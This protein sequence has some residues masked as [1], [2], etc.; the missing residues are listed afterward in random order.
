MDLISLLR[1]MGKWWLVV[2][3]IGILTVISAVLVNRAV[4]PIYEA[5]GAVVVT[6]PTFTA[7]A[8]TFD[9]LDLG[10]LAAA[11][12]QDEA[13][14]ALREADELAD[15]TIVD[16]ADGLVQVISTGTTEAAASSTAD[17]VA[18]LLI[19]ELDAVQED[20]DIE[21]A[22]RVRPRR[23]NEQA[24]VQEDAGVDGTQQF[25]A[26]VG[27]LLE[28]NAVEVQ[29]PYGATP[30]TGRLLQVAALSSEGTQR[31]S[32]LASEA[33]AF[34]IYQDW[35]DRAPILE[36]L[37]YGPNPES[38]MEGF[39][40]VTQTLSEVLDERQERAGVPPR[41]RVQIEVIAAPGVARDVSP[42]VNRAGAVTIALGLLIAAG[43]ALA[44]EAIAH[45]R[46][47]RRLA[48]QHIGD[49]PAQMLW[50]APVPDSQVPEDR[51][52]EQ[53]RADR[54]RTFP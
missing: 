28:E 7:S 37:T 5:S 33:V 2:A 54:S 13:L 9:G 29:N 51:T 34:D 31:V 6:P 30:Q 8:P 19:Q 32:N 48:S 21:E 15:F 41:Q 4:E 27:I 43:A 40:A 25:V 14:D 49:D 35:Q 53:T 24:A 36:V 20:L 50:P 42:P 47:S 12:R 17:L 44:S 39:D 18:T 38:T 16:A 26:N 45:R 10:E 1:I 52:T 22:A 11:V 3:P 46:R 23:I